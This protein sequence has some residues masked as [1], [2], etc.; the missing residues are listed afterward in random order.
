M[1]TILRHG[2]DE[3]KVAQPARSSRLGCSARSLQ[4]K[5]VPRRS[6]TAERRALHR[7][8]ISGQTLQ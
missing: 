6:I 1:G 3:E 5:E 7:L 8:T 4:V 2:G